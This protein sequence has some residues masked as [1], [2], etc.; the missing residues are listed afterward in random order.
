M[1]ILG[2]P[3]TGKT[4][5]SITLGI[6]ICNDEKS[7]LFYRLADLTS[8]SEARHKAGYKETAETRPSLELIGPSLV[9]PR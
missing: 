2:A 5:L 3:G 8:E 4:H 1:L 7:A 9:K 6:R